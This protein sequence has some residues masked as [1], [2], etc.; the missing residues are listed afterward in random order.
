MKRW[1][2]STDTSVSLS[3]QIFEAGHIALGSGNGDVEGFFHIVTTLG[4]FKI[5][6]AVVES[7]IS[8]GL[9]TVVTLRARSRTFTTHLLS[10]RGLA[11][12]LRPGDPVSLSVRP[13]QVHG[14]MRSPDF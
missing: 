8:D 3:R 14:A 5:G 7:L 11:R 4:N 12:R 6:K 2:N 1:M 13:D 10:G 9:A